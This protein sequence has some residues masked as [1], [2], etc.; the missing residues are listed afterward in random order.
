MDQLQKT[1]E[2][3]DYALMF[4]GGLILIAWTY[5]WRLRKWQD[6]LRGSP[7]RASSLTPAL[8]WLCIVINL[9]GWF[10]SDKLA[11]FLTP[12]TLPD[13]ALQSWQRVLSGGV[14]QTLMLITCLLVASYTFTSGLKGLGIGRRSIFSEIYAGLAGWLVVICICGV[15][16]LG[17]DYIVEWQEYE[18]P[19]HPVYR[20]LTESGVESWMR[21]LALVGAFILAPMG[22]ELFFRGI[23]QTGMK[24]RT[25]GWWGCC[26]VL[27][28]APC[29][30]TFSHWPLWVPSSGTYM[31][32]T[33]R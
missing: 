21:V 27:C 23:L 30:T 31:S 33:V 8:M 15:I 3:F 22:E 1:L 18:P 16:L 13:D 29:R 17:T 4:S 14:T 28:I 12:E 32:A 25:S 7:I 19:V 20:I 6:P 9:L 10:L 2:R 24:R 5:R 11:P 26:L